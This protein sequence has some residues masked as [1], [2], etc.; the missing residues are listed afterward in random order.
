MR[1]VME[2]SQLTHHRRHTTDCQGKRET[3][4]CKM[5]P[6]YLRPEGSGIVVSYSVHV[7]NMAHGALAYAKNALSIFSRRVVLSTP[8][9]C[10]L[11][12]T[13]YNDAHE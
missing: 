12:S 2:S 5:A 8:Y 6:S 7:E 4:E 9:K 13:P 10:F 1:F 3:V 11:H